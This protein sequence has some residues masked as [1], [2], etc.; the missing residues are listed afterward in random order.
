[1]AISTQTAGLLELYNQ[2]ISLDK[3]QLEQV[4]QVQSGYTITTGVGES[5]YIKVWGP[6]EV[7]DN[8]KYPIERLDNRILELNT[9]INTLKQNILTI[10]QQANNAGCG[11]TGVA[12]VSVATSTINCKVYSFSGN[13]PFE[14]STQTLSSSNLGVGVQ[15]SVVVVGL[16][17]YKGNVGTC[18]NSIFVGCGSAPGGSCAAAAA[19]ITYY[20]NQIPPLLSERDNLIEK[21][22]FLK[23]ARVDY[24]L[25]NY[26]YNKSTTQINSSIGISSSII[27]FL[28]DPNNASWV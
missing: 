2:K 6:Q 23:S 26:A 24:E 12:Y 11:T 17:S 20:Q 10:G 27:S 4:T 16:G 3:K 13:N 19:S 5:D 7:I 8:Y 1:M 15:N 21:V 28:T 25:Q 18:Y 22:N 14:E 9:Q